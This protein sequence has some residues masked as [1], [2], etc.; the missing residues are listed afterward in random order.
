MRLF[1]LAL[2]D[3]DQIVRDRKSLLFL[4]VMP[5]VFTLFMGLAY[6]GCP[7]IEVALRHG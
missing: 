6:R 2:K 4:V 1:T 5:I 7:A 3:L